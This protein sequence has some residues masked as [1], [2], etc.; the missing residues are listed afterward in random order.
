M[1]NLFILLIVLS[2]PALAININTATVDE[3]AAELSGVGPITAQ[4][5]V[6][7]RE[8]IGGFISIEQLMEIKGIGPKK[9]AR[10]KN[11]ISLINKGEGKVQ[12][13]V[14]SVTKID[15]S[16]KLEKPPRKVHNI[17]WDVLIIIPLFIICLSIFVKAWLRNGKKDQAVPRKHLLST[18]FVCARCAKVGE[19][20][21]IRYEGHLSNQYVDGDLPPGW[22]S[23]PNYLGTVCDYCFDCSENVD[24]LILPQPQKFLHS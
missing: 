9:L 1:K 13:K 24:N 4:R 22:S 15:L 7:Y 2:H 16:P 17:L 5:I 21:N 10:N 6:E 8:K 3:L 23:I 19:F 14:S 20:K 12:Q 11:K 18:I